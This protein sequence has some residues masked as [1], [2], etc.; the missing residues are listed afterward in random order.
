MRTLIWILITTLATFNITACPNPPAGNTYVTYE[1]DVYEGD[2]INNYGDDDSAEDTPADDDDSAA[3]EE[4]EPTRLEINFSTAW[5]SLGPTQI[6]PGEL[7]NFGTYMLRLTGEPGTEISIRAKGIRIVTK[8]DSGDAFTPW[9]NS[10]ATEISLEDHLETCV[11]RQPATGMVYQGP[12]NPD[13]TSSAIPFTE[14]FPMEV[15]EDGE[16]F[17]AIQL[18]CATTEAEP[19]D[20]ESGFAAQWEPSSFDVVDENGAPVDWS[21][22]S[23]NG[24]WANPTVQ[25]W[26]EAP[27]EPDVTV[28]MTGVAPYTVTRGE[29]DAFFGALEFSIPTGGNRLLTGVGVTLIGD[30]DAWLGDGAENDVSVANHISA[31]WLNTGSPIS[32]PEAPD[33][34]GHLD[35]NVNYVVYDGWQINLYCQMTQATPQNGDDDAFV[36]VFEIDDFEIE[37]DSGDMVSVAFGGDEALLNALNGFYVNVTDH[38][39]FMM[40]LDPSTPI[41]GDELVIGGSEVAAVFTTIGQYENVITDDLTFWL[42]GDGSYVDFVQVSYVNA[43]GTPVASLSFPD[44]NGQISYSNLSLFVQKNAY[45]TF[46]VQIGITAGAPSGL[47]YTVTVNPSGTPFSA[48]GENSGYTFSLGDIIPASPIVAFTVTTP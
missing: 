32:S 46:E 5:S 41:N 37:N 35:F 30:D 47:E 11:L 15:E 4:S 48:F 40:A 25:V 16:T 38:G 13:D 19:E 10:S 14:D 7:A 22:W 1:G 6:F 29:N 3:I 45:T 33:A 43:S 27:T 39:V 21:I 44:T 24:S 26:I 9:M 31:C 8:D 23:D 42:D 2:N 34:S 20:E 36:P 28:A 12:N 18:S 17:L